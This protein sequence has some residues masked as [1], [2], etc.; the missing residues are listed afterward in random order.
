MLAE[1]FLLRL[2]TILRAAAPN[3]APAAGSD[4]RFVPIT[5]P[6]A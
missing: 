6:R 1:I 2:Q 5:L 3:N 4:P